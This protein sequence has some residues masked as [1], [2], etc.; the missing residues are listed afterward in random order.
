MEQW[1]NHNVCRANCI[2]IHGAQGPQGATGPTG[3]NAVLGFLT[4]E[5]IILPSNS[6][7]TVSSFTGANG[8]FE[9]YDGVTRKTGTGITYSV[10][11]S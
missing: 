9:V 2:G 11:A 7:G 4:N 5:A 1:N 6:A 3:Q 8:T 10:F